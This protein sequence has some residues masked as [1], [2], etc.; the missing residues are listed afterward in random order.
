M[1]VQPDGKILVVGKHQLAGG[2][3]VL[4]RYNAHGT[5]DATFGTNGQTQ[6]NLG[7]GDERVP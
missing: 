1:L 2:N 3:Y 6:T 4:Q 5:L 7:G